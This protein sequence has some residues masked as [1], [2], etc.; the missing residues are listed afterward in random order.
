[1][2][3]S[4]LFYLNVPE[5]TA[6]ELEQCVGLQL[7]LKADASA[8]HN[9]GRQIARRVAENGRKL[10][11]HADWAAAAANISG[12]LVDVFDVNHLHGFFSD[13]LCG[14]FEIQLR[15]NRNDKD[16]VSARFACGHEGFVHALQRF[17]DGCGKGCGCIFGTP[18]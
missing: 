1:M 13:S 10:L 14:L 11:F 2:G 8:G 5:L 3:S 6:D 17:A 9:D 16:I 18:S 15:R 7:N 4:F 12:E